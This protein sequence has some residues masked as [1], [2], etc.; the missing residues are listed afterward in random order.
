MTHSEIPQHYHQAT[1]HHFHRSARS[2]GFMDWNNQPNPFRRYEGADLHLLPMTQEDISPA[3]KDLF[4]PAQ[5]PCQPQSA[6]H[7]STLLECALGLSAWKAYGDNR[8]ELRC[9]PSSGNLH[10][11]EGYLIAPALH[12]LTDSAGLYHYAPREHG[13]EERILLSDSEWTAL[14]T[15]FPEETFFVGLSSIHWREAWKYGERAYRYCQLD[16]GH[17]LAALS[18]SAAALGWRL[19]LLDDLATNEVAQLL[20]VDREEAPLDYEFEQADCLCAV[21][22]QRH[23]DPIPTGMQPVG[24]SP[25]QGAWSGHP[26]RLSDQHVPWEII[27]D[28]AGATLK[29]R[30]PTQVLQPLA[31]SEAAPDNIETTSPS[32]RQLFMQRRSAQSMD[33]QTGLDRPAFYQMLQRTLPQT[34]SSPWWG[35]Q[36]KAR[37]HLG[38]Y[39]HRV[40]GLEPGLYCLPRDSDELPRL[41]KA[42][43]PDFG[44]HVPSDCPASVPLYLLAT[45][46]VRDLAKSVSCEQDIAGDG[47]FSLAMLAAFQ[48]PL[49]ESGPWIY[50]RL[51]WEA[52]MVG[53]ILYLEAEAAGLQGTGIG[54]FFDDPVHESFGLKGHSYQSLYHFTIG[55]ALI[56]ERLQT[57]PPYGSER[58]AL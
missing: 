22:S 6:T 28:V 51:Y 33:G 5:I 26:N 3:Y 40:D 32:A 57:L 11:T 50:P 54:C 41:K 12:G 49:H 8:W 36:D 56:D 16:L 7:V 43:N 39:V 19:V 1:K 48:G 23:G 17:A 44:W 52:G 21:V 35:S 25:Y 45:G 4:Q 2:L 46:D 47:A 55:K 20:G 9:N 34:P 31:F 15:E 58:M 53:Q 10:P 18:L 38:I 13:L 14:C 29:P 37:I 27:D 24:L 30:T 42:M